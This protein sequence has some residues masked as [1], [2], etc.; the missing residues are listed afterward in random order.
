MC[1][2]KVLN[3][4]ERIRGRGGE[5]GRKTWMVGSQWRVGQKDEG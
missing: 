4:S 2:W 3:F 5:V 1:I